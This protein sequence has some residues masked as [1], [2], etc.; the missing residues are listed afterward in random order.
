MR[1]LIA[2]CGYVGSALAA[3]LVRSGAV[4]WGGRRSSHGLPPGVLPWSLDLTEPNLRVPPEVTHLVF[5]AAPD[6]SS[7]DAYRRVY[8]D[9]FRNI[10]GALLQDR[11]P[12]ERLIFV[13]STSVFAEQSG[14]AVDE[15]SPVVTSGKG[16]LLVEAERLALA[17][18]G[19]VVARLAGIYGPGRDRL[20]RMIRE[21]TARRSYPSPFGNRIHRDDAAGMIEHLLRLSF[22]ERCYLGVDDAPVPLDEVYLWLADRLGVPPPPVSNE[23]DARGRGALKRCLNARLRASGYRFLYPSYREG[24]GSL[25]ASTA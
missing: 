13:S 12:L 3:R 10:L 17:H 23:P 15:D 7:E 9:G 19:G 16:A 4:V 2:G 20:I 6:E 18:P 22:A 14:G 8:L 1:V 21:G 24:Y 25:L 5:C 11:A